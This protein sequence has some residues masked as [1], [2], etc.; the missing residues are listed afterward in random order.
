VTV[1]VESLDTVVTTV[2]MMLVTDAEGCCSPVGDGCVSLLEDEELLEVSVG[3]GAAE[4]LAGGAT[5]E[6]LVG[7][8]GVG[9]GEAEDLDAGGA[10]DEEPL[11]SCTPLA[12][13]F[14]F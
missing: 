11:L 14:E 5:D 4:E 2:V 13:S 8:L 1:L 9:V 10:A 6:E 7:G 12:V 3:E